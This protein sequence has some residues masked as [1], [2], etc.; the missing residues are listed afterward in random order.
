MTIFWI[1]AAGLTGLAVLFVV[2]PLLQSTDN[3]AGTDD[4]IDLA[5]VNLAL[6]KQQLAELDGDL[7]SGKLDQTQ[8]DAARHDLERE[9]LQNLPPDTGARN[10]AAQDNA[11]QDFAPRPGASRLPGPRATAL[12]LLVAVPLSAFSFYLAVGN[13]QIIPQIEAAARAGGSG[14]GHAGGAGMPSLEV[15]VA[16]LEDRMQQTPDD[17]E[18][19]VMLG[20]TYFSI[21]DTA[22]AEGALA[23][24]YALLP[25]DTQVVLTYAEA[26]AA[27]NGNNLQ[28]R[29]AELIAEALA[30]EPDN[31]TAQWLSGMGA[32]QRG[33]YNA[34]AAVWKKSLGQLDPQGEDA[35]ELR[36]LIAAA[37]ERAG[38]P[39]QMRTGATDDTGAE[40]DL[41]TG[42][43]AKASAAA[44][45]EAQ[46]TTTPAAAGLVVN[47]S[48]APELQQGL[49]P[50]ATVFVYAKAAA[51]PPMPLAAQRI[52]VADLP[53]TLRLDDSMAMAPAMTLSLFPQVV[54]GARVSPSGQAT[55]QPGDLEGDAGPVANTSTDTVLVR[56]DRVRP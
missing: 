2:A 30:L 44:P 23:R 51:G 32:F 28:G 25:T 47:V 14:Q 11:A 37:E 34:A 8:Y 56:I 10:A 4:D 31:P 26:V 5:Q 49:D 24:A 55:P 12:A 18:G 17:A 22:K 42:T 19:W 38:V 43:T 20:R 41:A 35:A 45:V 48:L 16:R 40:A 21:G 6:F 13:Q 36:Q 15:L 33:Q 27:N 46:A 7:A 50:R 3:D 53:A 39:P 9:A 52:T 29:P 54:V 1:L